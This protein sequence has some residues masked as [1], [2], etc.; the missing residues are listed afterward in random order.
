[1]S[2][3]LFIIGPPRSGTTLLQSMLAAHPLVGTLP[4]THFFETAIPKLGQKYSNPSESL[5]CEQLQIITEAMQKSGFG[6]DWSS[7]ELPESFTIREAFNALINAHLNG[8]E[9][10]WLEKTPG[11]A[12]F[13]DDIIRFYPNAK[14]LAIIRHPVESVSSMSNMK[15]MSMDDFRFSYI[16]PSKYHIELW[17]EC[18]EAILQK[19]DS[20]YIKTILYEDLVEDPK[21]I[22]NSICEFLGIEYKDTMVQE[23]ATVAKSLINSSFSPWKSG[24]VEPKIKDLRFKWRN[25]LSPG[26]IWL[27]ERQTGGL[28]TRLDYDRTTDP[29]LLS[30]RLA[31]LRESITLFIYKTQIEKAF[32]RAIVGISRKNGKS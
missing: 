18:C 6:F 22:L 32:R 26:R 16:R 24:N 23:F 30:K 17:K 12:R 13:I 2:A 4:E 20:H 25:K 10:F 1:M 3:P 21:A 31:I 8:N 28:M 15:P 5:Q 29:K 11:H 7:V 9:R 19:A 27:I 14:F